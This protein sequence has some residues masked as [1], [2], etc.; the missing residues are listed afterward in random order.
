MRETF[1]LCKSA[2]IFKVSY[3]NHSDPYT[4][5]FPME[6][7]KFNVAFSLKPHVEWSAKELAEGAFVVD[8]N[9]TINTTSPPWSSTPS[10]GPSTTTPTP[11]TTPVP[12]TTPVPAT[13]TIPPTDLETIKRAVPEIVQR[14]SDTT[15]LLNNF[16]RS[17]S[18]V[19]GVEPSNP[20]NNTGPAC[21]P[22]PPVEVRFLD[23]GI[24]IN[25]YFDFARRSSKSESERNP[26][27]VTDWKT[28]FYSSTV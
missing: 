10:W 1:N 27:S 21:C 25:F 4:S 11:S 6:Y 8:H 18:S 7:S 19:Q 3:H 24:D 9:S 12:V 23:T 16:A 13:S 5:K 14:I 2:K 20:A 22:A 28:N 17:A 26:I 15:G